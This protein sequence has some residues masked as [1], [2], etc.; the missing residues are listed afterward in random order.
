MIIKLIGIFL[1]I[2]A[3]LGIV[4]IF[5]WFYI[6][7]QITNLDWT[8]VRPVIAWVMGLM[9]VFIIAREELE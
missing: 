1:L 5:S 3:I 4:D 2:P 7:H 6:N 8:G 9:A